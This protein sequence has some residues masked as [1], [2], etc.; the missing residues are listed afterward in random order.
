LD[1]LGVIGSL[2]KI[3][4]FSE[5]IRNEETAKEGIPIISQCADILD[6]LL[7]EEL[8]E[9]SSLHNIPFIFFV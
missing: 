8:F 9:L 1:F 4:H 2:C 5:K 3:K 6:V 7:L